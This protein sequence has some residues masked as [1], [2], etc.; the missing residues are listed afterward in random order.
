L[1]DII[2]LVLINANRLYQFINE[3]H[4]FYSLACVKSKLLFDD[5]KTLIPQLEFVPRETIAKKATESFNCSLKKAKGFLIAADLI[6]T[7]VNDQGLALFFLH[8]STELV[9]RSLLIN[10]AGGELKTHSISTLIEQCARYIPQVAEFFNLSEDPEVRIELNYLQN[11]YIQGRYSCE[12]TAEKF[13]VEAISK[14]AK[15]FHE[16]A[17]AEFLNIIKT[18]KAE[19]YVKQ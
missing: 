8:Q 4:L 17:E 12:F 16:F 2:S 15:A 6:S 9:L 14:R 11:S 1:G 3:G 13:I 10:V 19:S 18:F 7:K 5:G